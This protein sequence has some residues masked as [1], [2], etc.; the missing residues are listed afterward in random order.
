[1]CEKERTPIAKGQ[2]KER[3]SYG[4]NE[5]QKVEKT[6]LA[7]NKEKFSS[8]D[9]LSLLSFSNLVFKTLNLAA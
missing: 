5:K 8:P 2:I 9:L 3:K 7:N 1:V 6:V 4:R